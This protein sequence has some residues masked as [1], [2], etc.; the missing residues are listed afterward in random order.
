MAAWPEL[1]SRKKAPFFPLKKGCGAGLSNATKKQTKKS[2]CLFWEVHFNSPP[3]KKCLRCRL[4]IF[5]YVVCFFSDSLSLWR[6]LFSFSM[7]PKHWRSPPDQWRV[8]SAAPQWCPPVSPVSDVVFVRKSLLE[9]LHQMPSPMILKN[10]A[11]TMTPYCK[12]Q[13]KIAAFLS[14]IKIKKLV[15]PKFHQS[16]HPQFFNVHLRRGILFGPR[17]NYLHN[18]SFCSF[19]VVQAAF[20]NVLQDQLHPGH[21][22]Q[23]SRKSLRAS[24][25]V[26]FCF[27]HFYGLINLLNSDIPNSNST[28]TYDTYDLYNV[29]HLN[30]LEPGIFNNAQ[31]FSP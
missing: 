12:N 15:K 5:L 2:G 21:M 18:H 27:S 7:L 23:D 26:M 16:I 24:F 4:S 19:A 11:I 22:F 10:H 25:R 13:K 14:K 3:K 1:C 6:C 17:Q 31:P 29:C 20:V 8:Q 9:N 30:I 28:L